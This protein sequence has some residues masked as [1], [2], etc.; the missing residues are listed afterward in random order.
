VLPVLLCSM[1]AAA[2][3]EAKPEAKPAPAIAKLEVRPV[4]TSKRP[5]IMRL[6]Q[7][8]Q[9]GAMG[10]LAVQ[11]I[12]ATFRQMM[13]QVKDELWQELKKEI[14]A[15][16]LLLRL[17]PVYDKHFSSSE[18]KE[19]IRFY[20]SPIGKKTTQMM[21]AIN[22][23]AMQI[24][25]QWGSEVSVRIKRRIDASAPAPPSPAPSAAAPTKK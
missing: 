9:A 12:I 22:Q 10:E 20:E 25:Q 13:P 19:L 16:E 7:L 2:Q 11:Q 1:T 23:E 14:S 5:D 6:L 18:L 21:P 24:G 4:E 15:E 3:G 17:V 8:T